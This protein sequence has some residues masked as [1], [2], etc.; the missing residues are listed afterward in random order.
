[1]Q[2]IATK[3]GLQLA[4]QLPILDAIWGRCAEKLMFWAY[5]PMDSGT[6]FQARC[7]LFC[8][9]WWVLFCFCL[10]LGVVWFILTACVSPFY[11]SSPWRLRKPCRARLQRKKKFGKTDAVCGKFCGRFFLS[12]RARSRFNRKTNYKI[13]KTVQVYNSGK[14]CGSRS[15][16]ILA[17]SLCLSKRFVSSFR[18]RSTHGSKCKRNRRRRATSKSFCVSQPVSVYPAANFWL[19][20]RASFFRDI[21]CLLFMLKLCDVA[22]S[23]VWLLLAVRCKSQS[24]ELLMEFERGGREKKEEDEPFQDIWKE[25]DVGDNSGAKCHLEEFFIR[26]EVRGSQGDVKAV[27]AAV[28]VSYLLVMRGGPWLGSTKGSWNGTKGSV[29]F[30]SWLW[31]RGLERQSNRCHRCRKVGKWRVKAIRRRRRSR[32]WYRSFKW[33]A[34]V[35]RLRLSQVSS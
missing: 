26:E 6:Y 23:C 24:M 2:G 3:V 18:H 12:W 16:E 30:L 27:E 17:M 29:E 33:V 35:V 5:R 34:Y 14:V 4:S 11:G 31:K 13:K 22:C 1:M 7:L 9:F 20:N 28:L 10:V 32:S 15:F 8:R 19:A 21:A 25:D